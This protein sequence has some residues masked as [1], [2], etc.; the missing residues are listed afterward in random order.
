MITVQAALNRLIDGNELFYDEMLHLMRQI[1]SGELTPVQTA[2]L[3]MGLR[4]KV[5]SVSEIAAAATVMR[6]F[7]TPVSVADR[8]HLV[9]IVGTG[10]DRLHSFNIST[11]A[12]FVL[13]AAGGR[14]AKHGN[15]AVSSS[16][17][18]ADALEALGVNLSA[19]AGQVG[20]CID[21]LGVGF[22]FAPN[23]HSAMKYVAPVRREMGVR[24]IFNILGPLTNP[25]KAE[26]QLIGVFHT[27]LVGILARVLQQM[28]SKH[29]MVVMGRDGMD[30][31]TL[32]DTTQV[33]ELKNGVI[34]EYEFD[35][36]EFGFEFCT[37][38]DLHAGNAAES[39]AIVRNVLAGK[40][41]P[42]RDIVTLN[43]GAAIYTANLV[44]TLQAG[45]A[46]AA[47]VIDSGAAQAKL[48]ALVGMTQSF[49]A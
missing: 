11:T 35:P 6:E 13:A 12:M 1:M 22:M 20:E 15:R 5:E 47:E 17:G 29:A 25:A 37:M 41:G 31:I 48:D 18:S 49:K 14:V 26:N 42:T 33:A 32:T 8:T 34:T 27:D 3:L 43:A 21:E 45:F 19:T 38:Q 23:H 9:D 39:I 28:G 2:A 46:K 44:P 7:A 10:G 4:C 24:T 16:S 40:P 36:R 30:E